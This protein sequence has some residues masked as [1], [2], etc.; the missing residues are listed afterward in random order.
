M[1]ARRQKDRLG[2]GRI[3]LRVQREAAERT[4]DSAVLDFSIAFAAEHGLTVLSV[5]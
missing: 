4:V 1:A 3:P 5:M 2:L